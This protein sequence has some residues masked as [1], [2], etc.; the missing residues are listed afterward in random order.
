[1]STKATSLQA[2]SLA[3]SEEATESNDYP[4][5]EDSLPDNRPRVQRKVRRVLKFTEDEDC[6]LREGIKKHGFGQ[7]TAILRDFTFQEGRVADS[8]KK[9]AHSKFL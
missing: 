7:W 4:P 1:M 9:R 3:A 2:T 8:L 5:K 6:F